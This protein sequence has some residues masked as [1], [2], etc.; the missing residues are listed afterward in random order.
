MGHPVRILDWSTLSEAQRRQVLERPAQRDAGEIHAAVRGIIDAVRRDGEAAVLALTERFD[1][2]RLASL[3]V[4]PQEFAAAERTLSA[5]Q[6]AAIERATANASACRSARLVC[7]CLPVPR[8]CLPRPSC[9]PSPRPSP[10]AH[11]V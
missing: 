2:A 9:S 7:T 1:R 11:R 5:A 6:K 8:R 3:R 10:N 4:T